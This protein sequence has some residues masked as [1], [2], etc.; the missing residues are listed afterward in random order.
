MIARM[1]CFGVVLVCAV[2]LTNGAA[3]GE[4]LSPGDRDAIRAVIE[5]QIAAFRRDDADGAF[6]FAAP[7]IREKFGD[8]ATFIE[9]VRG[10]YR[11]VYRPSEVVFRDIDATGTLPIQEVLV[12]DR[13]GRSFIAHYPMQKQPDGH[14]LIAGCFLA[15]FDGEAT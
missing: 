12:V 7:F 6:S 11:P 9:M 14:W 3:A 1:R 2:A 8:A 13:E 15:P 4:P 10:G 5:S